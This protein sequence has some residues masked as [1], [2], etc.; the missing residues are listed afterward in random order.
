MDIKTHLV[1]CMLLTL[2]K[3]M[4]CELPHAP[5]AP[6]VKS[7]FDTGKLNGYRFT[8]GFPASALIWMNLRILFISIFQTPVMRFLRRKVWSR[9]NLR[10]MAVCCIFCFF[11]GIVLY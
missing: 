10:R 3:V 7:I 2:L 9:R 6:E 1:F 8:D 4:G 5:K 11:S